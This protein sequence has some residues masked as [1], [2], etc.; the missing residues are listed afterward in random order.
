MILTACRSGE[1]LNATW[2]EIDEERAMWLIP[3]SRMKARKEE[4]GPHRVPLSAAA[5]AVLKK[6]KEFRQSAYIFPGVRSGRP[7]S[8]MSLTQLLRRMRPGITTHGFRSTFR[9]WAAEVTLYP[10]ELAEM[11]LA[12]VVGNKVEAAYRRGDMFDKR[13]QMMTDWAAW[14][15]PK[16]DNV[17]PISSKTA[18]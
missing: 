3:A 5:M 9:D 15:E 4:Q 7:M 10:H 13:R 12:H 6:A 17:I 14:C 8:D 2:D 11:A 16:E 1:G 18:A